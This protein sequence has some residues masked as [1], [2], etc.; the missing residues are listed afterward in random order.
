MQWLDG[1][2]V[3]NTCSAKLADHT[4]TNSLLQSLGIVEISDSLCLCQLRWDGYVERSIFCINSPVTSLVIPGDRGRGRLRK[5]WSECVRKEILAH[6]LLDRKFGVLEL[7]KAWC[8]LPRSLG[9]PQHPKHQNRM[10]R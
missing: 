5:T 6:I 8:C 3:L 1:Y 4:L 2:A 7:D 9:H 10:V